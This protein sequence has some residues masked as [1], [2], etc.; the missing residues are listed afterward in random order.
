MNYNSIITNLFYMLVKA[1]GNINEKEIALG[2]QMISSEGIRKGEFNLQMDVAKKKNRSVLLTESI[3]G[4][5][6]LDRQRQIR[7]IAW[8]CVVAN[9]DGF[10]DRTEWH[11]IYNLYHRELALP[12][13][14]IM[15]AQRE[16]GQSYK[17]LMPQ[18][19]DVAA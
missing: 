2:E 15:K 8:L 14:E 5:R 19:M 3:M 16:L 12:L 1:D 17:S 4:L 13:D 9:A 6:S 18:P 11:F 10:M 7:V